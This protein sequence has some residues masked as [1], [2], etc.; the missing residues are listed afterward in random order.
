MNK[1]FIETYRPS[2]AGYDPFLIREGWQVAQLNY[3][4]EQ[5][6]NSMTRLEQHTL[7]DEVFLLTQG[8]AILIA[9]NETAGRFSFQLI[10]MNPGSTYNIPENTWHNIALGKDAQVI[11]IERSNT[12][13]ADVNYRQLNKEDR[14]KLAEMICKLLVPSV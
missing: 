11:I 12:H 7:T 14:K 13:L 2:G 10:N 9:G 1:P 3:T 8:T 6:I 4:P 5:G